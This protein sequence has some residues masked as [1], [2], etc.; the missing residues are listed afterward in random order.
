MAQNGDMASLEAR[1]TTLG[2]QAEQLL[3]ILQRVPKTTSEPS[4]L[5]D[6]P[7]KLNNFMEDIKQASTRLSSFSQ[8]CHDATIVK[9]EDFTR[10]E[11]REEEIKRKEELLEQK[12]AEIARRE[13][14][15]E[16][17]AAEMTK[18]EEHRTAEVAKGE[19]L[20][21][22]KTRAINEREALI[23]RKSIKIHVAGQADMAKEVE[24][25]VKDAENALEK[26]LEI[27]EQRRKADEE[28]I[29]RREDNLKHARES[30]HRHQQIVIQLHQSTKEKLESIRQESADMISYN[31][32]T[33]QQL[34]AEGAKVQG[35]I[36][37]LQTLKSSIATPV[38]NCE[39]ALANVK[40]EAQSLNL[41]EAKQREEI[42]SLKNDLARIS[43]STDR[44]MA[45]MRSISKDIE[46]IDSDRTRLISRQLAGISAKFQEMQVAESNITESM[47]GAAE[48]LRNATETGS[49]AREAL[50]K[51]LVRRNTTIFN[52]NTAKRGLGLSSP[53]KP[54]T[55]RRRPGFVR[56]G[57]AG[58]AEVLANVESPEL[59][60]NTT[61]T[62]GYPNERR[63]PLFET[64][65]TE[66]GAFGRLAPF[67]GPPAPNPTPATGQDLVNTSRD[68][69]VPPGQGGGSATDPSGLSMASDHVR[70]V[71]RQLEFPADWTTADSTKLLAIFNEAKARKGGK[72]DRHWPQ[73]AMDA[74][75][76]STQ[77]YCLA[78]DLKKARMMAPPDGRRCESHI[79]NVLCLDVFYLTNSPGEYDSAAT[80]KR[81]R[82]E[83]RQ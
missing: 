67:T 80:D 78:R 16:Q 74:G 79:P 6:W 5:D 44:H 14:L 28:M 51:V 3:Q 66:S 8:R 72:N 76:K 65:R 4:L 36:K 18:R 70:N 56:E 23:Q 32:T 1:L 12:A 68:T 64:P 81:W 82:L 35:L 52:D 49:K 54:A 48:E 33:R 31:D 30:L 75:S 19:E 29:Q 17:K 77:P 42:A 34:W 43:T 2:C 53:E 73:Q 38:Q 11:R 21:E 39:A 47:S 45:A 37:R 61:Q 59:L 40:K 71:W 22:Q 50:Q 57:S 15:L 27:I 7:D 83:K 20:S 24:A 41:F 60:V 63:R 62:L 9:S 26:R 46:A 69:I 25:Q 55:K 10:V 58:A 13:E